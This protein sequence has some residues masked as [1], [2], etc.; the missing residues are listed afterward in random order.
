MTTNF[1][2]YPKTNLPEE[3][4][5]FLRGNVPHGS[6]AANYLIAYDT[7]G[8][9]G[10]LGITRHSTLLTWIRHWRVREDYQGMGIGT[11]LL[12]QA[13]KLTTTPWLYMTILENNTC[14]KNAARRQGFKQAMYTGGVGFWVLPIHRLTE[15]ID[16]E[17]A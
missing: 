4:E 6:R 15:K 14:S 2:I 1:L 8:V 10:V 5:H 11:A 13:I 17:N 9:K 12:Q 16:E 3:V 7:G